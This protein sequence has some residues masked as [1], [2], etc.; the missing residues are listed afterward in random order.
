MKWTAHLPHGTVTALV[1]LAGVVLIYES[2]AI[3]K[4]VSLTENA[5]NANSEATLSA[6]KS[7]Q[8]Q[9]TDRD[10]KI[11]AESLKVASLTRSLGQLKVQNAHLQAD[12]ANAKTPQDTI[13]AQGK[14]IVNL[15]SQNDTLTK[16]C[17]EQDTIISTCKEEKAVM[18]VRIDT[19]ESALKKQVASTKC[20]ILFFGCPTRTAS[21][22]I[23]GV[24]GILTTFIIKSV[25]H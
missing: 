4:A 11:S 9:I 3:N 22:E 8:R 12:L 23:G 18:Q 1:I 21:F 24:A 5:A 2:G 17:A 25:V 14:I 16:K 7:F 13:S 10:S 19:L 6:R 20:H 15:K